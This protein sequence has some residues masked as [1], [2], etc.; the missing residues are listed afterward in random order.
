[1][2]A[3]QLVRNGVLLVL[4]VS[5]AAVILYVQARFDTADRHAGL[6]LVHEYH[7]PK[8]RTLPEILAERH[9]GKTPTWS[10]TTESGCLQHIRVSAAVDDPPGSTTVYEFLIDI[11]GPSIHPGNPAGQQAI[12]E[13]DVA[14]PARAIPSPSG[15]PGSPE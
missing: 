15:N 4:S 14:K 5:A 6:V 1:M 13:L 12:A 10:T 2:N 8:G 3:K 11:N 9:P 7:S